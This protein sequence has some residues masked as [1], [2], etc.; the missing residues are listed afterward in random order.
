MVLK[1]SILYIKELKKKYLGGKCFGSKILKRAVKRLKDLFFPR[2]SETRE[3][4]IINM[5]M[6]I[7]MC[8]YVYIRVYIHIYVCIYIYHFFIYYY[9]RGGV[10][11]EDSSEK[12]GSLLLPSH[13]FQGWNHVAK[14]VQ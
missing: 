1:I 2:I 3:E 11:M 4:G 13:A 7:H 8:V 10:K 12:S 6:Y 9:C 5:C 14:F